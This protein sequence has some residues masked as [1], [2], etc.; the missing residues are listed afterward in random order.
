[1]ADVTATFN[2]L[3]STESS[4]AP[5][6]TTT[7]G[8][9]LAPNLRMIEA[10][11]AAWRDEM[12]WGTLTLTTVAGT[13]NAITATLA[14]AGSV[15]FGPTSYVT[16]SRFLLTPASTNTGAT[17]LNVTSPAG[18]SA[19]G[20]KNVFWNGAACVGGEL[21]AS[22]PCVV[23]YDGT[24]FHIIANAFNHGLTL[25]TEQASTSGTSIDFT[26]IP[27][28]VKRITML[29]NGVSTNGTS[30]LLVQI[31]PTAA[32]ETTGYV[33]GAFDGASATS[34][35]GYILTRGIVAANT[36]YGPVTLNLQ[37][38]SSFEWTASAV[39]NQN[40]AATVVVSGGSK[41]TAAEVAR[42]RLTTVNGSDAFDAGLVNISYEF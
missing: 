7:V 27:S 35:A 13:A 12:A 33:S 10:H 28:G 18:G 30:N 39:L 21:R 2:G 5:A 34:T 20:A 38:A 15:T 8:S 4:N 14:T 9:N 41:S 11:I 29:L 40:G 3:S 32:V 6:G 22:V 42:I 16:G 1:M 23:E 19:L 36:F 37:N 24:Q 31:G 26:G 17:T 25:A